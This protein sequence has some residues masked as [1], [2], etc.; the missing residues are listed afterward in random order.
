MHILFI[1]IEGGWGGSSRSLKYLIKNIDP[2]IYKPIVFL[3]KDGP[4]EQEYQ[5]SNIK[6]DVVAPLP[7]TTAMLSNNW[8]AFIRFILLQVYM[9]RLLLK[10]YSTIK[11]NNIS[12]IHL[13][14]ESLF[15]IGMWCSLFFKVKTV[16]HVR[17]YAA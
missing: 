10:M 8:R 16:Y 6:V 4:A 17:T 3:G 13:N 7:R 9:P 2:R 15:Y 11:K 5:L 12:I 14:H 1:D